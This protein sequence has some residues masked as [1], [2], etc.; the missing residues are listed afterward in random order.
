M[1]IL[2]KGSNAVERLALTLSPAC[3]LPVQFLE[4]AEACWSYMCLEAR[5]FL[6]ESEVCYAYISGFVGYQQ[7]R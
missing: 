5:D 1:L 7:V 4:S 6:R 2:G 3:Q